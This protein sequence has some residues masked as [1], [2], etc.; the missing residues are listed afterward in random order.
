M[1][2]FGDE[3]PKNRRLTPQEMQTELEI[4]KIFRR[5]PRQFL[6]DKPFYPYVPQMPKE[7]VNFDLNFKD[8]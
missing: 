3:T 6:L 5:H 7:M 8:I 4:C 1:N 2:L